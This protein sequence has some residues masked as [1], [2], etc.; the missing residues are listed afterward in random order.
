MLV[1][2]TASATGTDFSTPY[3][4]A[5][6]DA[7]LSGTASSSAFYIDEAADPHAVIWKD[8]ANSTNAVASWTVETSV[9]CYVSVSLDLG[10]HIG[11]SNAHNFTVR[12]KK[13]NELKG[14][15]TEGGEANDSLTV[16][17]LSGTILIPAEGTYTVEVQNYRDYGK[18]S[19]RNVILTY[20]ADAPSETIEV[21][22]VEL[23]KHAVTLDLQEV[24]QLTATVLP[25]NA[26][27]PTVTWSS[28]NEAVATVDA[29]GFITAL[30]AGTAN[31]TATAGEKSDVCAVTVAAAAVPDVE[32]TSSY[33]LEAKVAHLEGNIFKKYEG[34]KYKIYG[35]GNSHYGNAFW[36]IHVTN[37]C[38]LSA[39]IMN[40][41][42]DGAGSL[43]E[44]DVFKGGDSITTIIQPSSTKWY[45]GIIDMTGTITLAEAADY[46]FRLRNTQ[47]N[48][49]GKTSGISLTKETEPI[50]IYLKAGVWNTAGAKFGVYVREEGW[51]PEFMEN[52]EGDL[53]VFRNFPANKVKLNFVR[54]ADIKVAPGE[55]DIWNQVVDLNREGDNNCMNITGWGND[56]YSTGEWRK[57][58]PGLEAGYYLVGTHNSWEPKAADILAKNGAEEE[59]M[60]TKNAEEGD[61]FKAISIDANGFNAG[62]Y[63]DGSGNEYTIPAELAGN[64]T[65]Y[66]R[67][68]GNNEWPDTNGGGKKFYVVRNGD[69]T[70][71]DHTV[72]GEKAVKLMENGQLVIIKNGVRYNVLG[73]VIK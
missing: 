69:P 24:E 35:K 55:G 28:D 18:G 36:T 3:Y 20:A 60:I 2:L 9:G 43:Y 29:T 57:Y 37:P 27:E 8:V 1:A 39:S 11:S 31:I 10:R 64:V 19:I 4:C 54:F 50:D 22:S 73:T 66:F 51:W 58:F 41:N 7:V 25:D 38:I 5:A 70:A 44:L 42:G 17:P 45:S 23:N 47:A 34:E 52:V 46:T 59:Y 48:S 56:G 33:T 30:A 16:K 32:I 49:V 65:I 15:V 63:P 26:T 68:D 71:I 14:S 13:G 61:Q 12:I 62:W 67:P 6:D 40:A 53:Y 72:V 21:S